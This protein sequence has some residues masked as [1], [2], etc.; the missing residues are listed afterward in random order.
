MLNNP[1]MLIGSWATHENSP[2]FISNSVYYHKIFVFLF[3]SWES[4]WLTAFSF[5]SV[6]CVSWIFLF[7]FIPHPRKDNVLSCKLLCYLISFVVP[8]L[9]IFSYRVG[10][11]K[12][13]IHLEIKRNVDSLYQFFLNWLF[14]TR[15]LRLM[16]YPLHH[17]NFYD[18]S[19]LWVVL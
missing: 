5:A 15:V 10:L 4:F 14:S 13:E 1:L 12:T 17:I 16:S 8:K 11:S 2:D 6:Y 18:F 19:Y 3:V 9:T 7:F